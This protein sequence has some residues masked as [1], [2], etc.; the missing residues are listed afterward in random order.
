MIAT[1]TATSWEHGRFDVRRGPGKLL[2]GCVYE[3]ASIELGAF[4]SGGRVFCIASAGCTA[5]KLAPHHEVVAVD[6]NPVQL[7]YAERRFA[8]GP[9]ERGTAERV[10]AFARVLGPLAGWRPSRL[11]T[12][13]ELDDPTEQIIYWRRCLDTRRFRT[14][15]DLLLSVPA[16]R[17]IYAPSFLHFLPP[18]LGA[19]MRKRMERCFALH[20]NRT[21]PYART[22]LLG[23]MSTDRP[24]PETEDIRLVHADAATF[25]EGEPA[26]SFDGVTLSNILDGASAA[27]EQRLF[28]AV[29]R[30]A[31][32]GAVAV[33]R[34]F[35]EPPFKLPTNHAAE[36]RAM[37]WGIV[38]VRPAIDL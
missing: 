31:A 29:K 34:S 21:N 36:D 3:D 4:P 2:F 1:I 15:F 18:N 5:M 17:S 30:V 26:G 35:R 33:L 19:F 38:D 14:A 23:E 12:F 24:P 13:L 37:L 25:L 11:R 10:L 16:L 27:Y 9:R 20:S 22:L 32:P 28:A 7:A 8:G 6:L